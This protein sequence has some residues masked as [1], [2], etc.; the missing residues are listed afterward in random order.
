MKAVDENRVDKDEAMDYVLA[1][2]AAP[3]DQPIEGLDSVMPGLALRKLVGQTTTLGNY[4]QEMRDADGLPIAG[5]NF[6]IVLSP[7]KAKIPVDSFRRNRKRAMR[8]ILSSK[9][10]FKYNY[11]GYIPARSYKKGVVMN[12]VTADDYD[13]Y[14]AS[15]Y[16]DFLPLLIYQKKRQEE[17]EKE[18]EEEKKELLMELEDTELVNKIA[19]SEAERVRGLFTP[20]PDHWKPEVLN[21][22]E[23]N[24]DPSSDSVFFPENRKGL[25]KL[26]VS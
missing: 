24:R 2:P 1:C 5:S 20:E 12:F 9:Y 13:D 15:T 10:H 21:Y 7:M 6:Q 3:I 4:K 26:K 22:M 19:E 14:L 23:D 16:C 18:I 8:K 17:K 25:K 11:G